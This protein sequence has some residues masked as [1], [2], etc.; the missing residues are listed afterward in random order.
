MESKRIT[1]GE[2][3]EFEIVWEMYQYSFPAHEKRE[4]S[5]QIRALQDKRCHLDLFYDRENPIGFMLWWK[6]PEFVYIEHIAINRNIRGKGYGK[7][8]LKDFCANE[9]LPQILEI[10]PLTDEVAKRRWHFYKQLGYVQNPYRHFHRPYREGN[11]VFEL[12]IL[13]HKTPLPETLYH[14]FH[15]EHWNHIIPPNLVS[16]F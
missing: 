2:C 3:P 7:Q 12:I 8:I 15:D 16:N 4:K 14:T 1:S 5:E 13:S 9:T 11:D 6:Y 10:D